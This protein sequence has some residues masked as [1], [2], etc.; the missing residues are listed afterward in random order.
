MAVNVL[1]SKPK[2]W[3]NPYPL[4]PEHCKAMPDTPEDSH[5]LAGP[6]STIPG[7]LRVEDTP[8]ESVTVSVTS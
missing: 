8:L 4:V 7:T 3:V 5:W 2:S 6:T 1:V